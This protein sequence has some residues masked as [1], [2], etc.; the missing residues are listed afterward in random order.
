MTLYK[1]PFENI[2]GKGENAGNHI[3]ESKI[4]KCGKELIELKTSQ[5]YKFMSSYKQKIDLIIS[6][7]LSSLP[8]AHL[9]DAPSRRL[10]VTGD[11]ARIQDETTENSAWFF[12]VLG[13]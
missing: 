9:S 6:V 1:K 10:V 8:V 5:G 11:S 13:V 4:L 2:V 12:N 3:A 7:Y